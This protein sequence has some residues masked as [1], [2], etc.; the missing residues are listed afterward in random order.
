[1]K[2]IRSP[3]SN[4]FTLIEVLAV[5]A[6]MAAI[7]TIG[8]VAV[9]DTKE[10][11][12]SAKLESDVS[13]INRSIQIFQSNGGSLAGL[14]TTDTVLAKLKTQGDP[15]KVLGVTSSVLD[16]RIYPVYQ[17]T[18]EASS[19]APRAVWRSG[20][21]RFVVVESG[22]GGVKEFRLNE[23]LAATDPTLDTS[24]T[25]AKE[26]TSGTGWVWSHAP[27]AEVAATVGV[28]PQA[29]ASDT[30]L[31][32]AINQNFQS[33]YW[34]IDASGAVNVNYVFREAG[35]S[36]RLALFSLSRGW[37]RTS[38]IWIQQPD[39]KRFSWRRCGG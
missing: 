37:G 11:A 16:A 3:Q 18:A 23:E 28:T 8:Y 26:T 10:S 24:R 22:S 33:G 12:D 5:L 39:R 31:S 1:M 36:S 35:Y 17:T 9:S 15:S 19:A 14:S 29:G 30:A 38:M 2:A 21:S 13:S 27:A 32:V 34:T 6:A 7:G 25:T 4:G 20:E